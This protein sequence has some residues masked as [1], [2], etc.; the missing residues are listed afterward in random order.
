MKIGVQDIL[1]CHSLVVLCR[2]EVIY[3]RV[4]F[5]GAVWAFY[6]TQPYH[7][8]LCY[9]KKELWSWENNVLEQVDAVLLLKA[10]HCACST[11]TI[12]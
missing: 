6:Y 11:P 12:L 7:I 2:L 8:F 1:E 5:L 4:T 10:K 3:R 9:D